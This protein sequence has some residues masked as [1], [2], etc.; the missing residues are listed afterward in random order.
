MVLRN[1]SRSITCTSSRVANPLLYSHACLRDP[2]GLSVAS[3][4][5][6]STLRLI[7]L[8]HSATLD[9]ALLHEL[10]CP[11]LAKAYASGQQF[12]AHAWPA[13]LTLNLY[14]DDIN[15]H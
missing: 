14:I 7:Q 3:L 8:V 5:E 4:S 12:L 15:L 9:A 1:A 11:L 6:E 2:C 10:T 13:M